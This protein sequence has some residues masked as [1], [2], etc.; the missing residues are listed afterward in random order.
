MAITVEDGTGLITADSFVSV[1]DA[2]AYH[3]ARGNTAW[4]G[5][6]T[7][8]GQ[9]LVR[10]TTY[11]ELKYG[12][13]WAGYRKTS[14]Q[15]LSWPRQFVPIPNMYIPEYLTDTTIPVEIKN[16]CTVLALKALADELIADEER[17]V[18]SES[19]QGATS[20]TYSEFSGQQ[21]VYPEITLMVN[22]YLAASSGLQVIRV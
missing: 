19:V 11:L 10:A 5:S 1:I 12:L 18:I 22:K 4:A 14:T 9:A 15:A 13:R 8:K 6:D 3:T 21:K 2:D 20:T 17:A 7:V 16:A